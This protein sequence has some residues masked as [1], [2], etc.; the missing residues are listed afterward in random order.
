VLSRLRLI[1]IA[2]LV[3]AATAA[4]VVYDNLASRAVPQLDA[5]GMAALRDEFNA[6]ADAARV[7]VLLSP[8]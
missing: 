7:I 3:A 2:A 8:T 5:A 4:I 6:S 1:L